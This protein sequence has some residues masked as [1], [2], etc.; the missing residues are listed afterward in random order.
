MH[1]PPCTTAERLWRHSTLGFI[2]Q[3]QL[4]SLGTS[5]AR[6]PALGWMRKEPV[7]SEK[8]LNITGYCI[9]GIFYSYSE[10]C[11]QGHWELGQPT[12]ARDLSFCKACYSSLYRCPGGA[13]CRRFWSPAKKKMYYKYTIWCLVG[14]IYKAYIIPVCNYIFISCPNVRMASGNLPQPLCQFMWIGG[15]KVQSEIYHSKNVSF[16]S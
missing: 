12:S 6:C 4:G 14:H 8:I 9:L 16:H 5:I 2:P 15:I 7:C 1:F 3:V 13:G 11:R 10:N